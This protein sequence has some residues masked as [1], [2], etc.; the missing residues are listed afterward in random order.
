MTSEIMPGNGGFR[1]FSNC[2]AIRTDD[3]HYDFLPDFKSII[4]HEGKDFASETAAKPISGRKYIE[5][6]SF[7]RLKKNESEVILRRKNIEN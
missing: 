6:K 1:D 2:I 5:K 3:F 7:L 4:Y